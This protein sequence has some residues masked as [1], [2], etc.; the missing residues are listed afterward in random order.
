M[1]YVGPFVLQDDVD[2][3]WYH[4]NLII[5]SLHITDI[6]EEE[7]YAHVDLMSKV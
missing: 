5:A 4:F 2:K 3:G 7:V 6:D 1:M